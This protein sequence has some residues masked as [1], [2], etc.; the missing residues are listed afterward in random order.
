MST[1][2]VPPALATPTLVSDT[3]VSKVMLDL[4]V[5][6]HGP[7]EQELDYLFDLFQR[8]CPS[9]RLLRYK[10]AELEFWPRVARPVL[11]IHGREA[12]ARG[13][14]YPYFEPVRARIRE[15]RGFEA[16]FWDGR[17]IDDAEGSWNFDCRRIHLRSTGLFSFARFLMPLS[18][19]PEIIHRAAVELAGNVAIHSGHGGLVFAYDVSM[20]NSAFD[21]IYAQARRFWGV[22]VEHMKGTLP[23]TRSRI[24]SVSW[25]T[26]VGTEFTSSPDVASALND[27]EIRPD[28]TVDY[29]EQATVIAVGS[30]PPPGDQHRPDNSLDGMY[31]VAAALKP[32]LLEVHPDFP[33]QRWIENGNTVGWLRRFLEPER[34]R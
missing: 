20:L 7:S 25:L 1:W 13:V 31:A 4:T 26:L 27:L 14:K 10:I 18:T 23:L 22:D 29:R 9:D 8:T 28:V 15:G 21:A 3:V 33:S 32:L 17:E 30:N 16:Q 24:K 12:A 34:W 5:Y 19:S 11:T 2:S 6:L